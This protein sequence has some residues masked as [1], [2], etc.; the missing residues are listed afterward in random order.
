[1]LCYLK[2]TKLF[3]RS[4]FLLKVRTANRNS[5]CFFVLFLFYVFSECPRRL[6]NINVRA[7]VNA[8]IIYYMRRKRGKPNLIESLMVGQW[9][10]KWRQ[11]CNNRYSYVV[12]Q[13][14]RKAFFL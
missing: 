14:C 6:G 1:M 13:R 2:E 4:F 11:W 8:Q 12:L 7:G 5:V 9:Y 10:G 3:P